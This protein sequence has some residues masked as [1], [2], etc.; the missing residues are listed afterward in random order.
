MGA[1]LQTARAVQ[2]PLNATDAQRSPKYPKMNSTMTTAPTSQ[3][4]LF[5]IAFPC[6]R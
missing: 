6:L 4:I 1:V 2:R 3:M 5:M